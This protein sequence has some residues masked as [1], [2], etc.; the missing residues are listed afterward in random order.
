MGMET[1]ATQDAGPFETQGKLKARRY[2]REI[3]SRP[4]EAQG[5]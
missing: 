3:K 5:K 4:F 1:G 2:K